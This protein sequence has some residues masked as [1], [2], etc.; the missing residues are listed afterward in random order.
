M[1]VAEKKGKAETKYADDANR[2]FNEALIGP[3]KLMKEQPKV[4]L[5]GVLNWIPAAAFSLLLVDFLSKYGSYGNTFTQIVQSGDSAPIS[6]FFSRAVKVF[7]DYL[8]DLILLGIVA[9]LITS[10]VALIYAQIVVQRRR[11][12]LRKTG[13]KEI[14]LN[15]AFDSGFRN[16]FGILL[17]YI[18]F[19]VIAI[20][21]IIIFGTLFVLFAMLGI[22]GVV[23]IIPLIFIL[24]FFALLYRLAGWVLSI[25]IV[26]DNKDGVEA[27]RDCFGFAWNNKLWGIL[28]L[29][30][31]SIISF[32]L[33]QIA[34]GIGGIQM[35]GVPL[36]LVVGLIVGSWD[37]MVPAEMYF[38]FTGRKPRV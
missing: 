10:L 20:G 14:M 4:L 18:L 8:P 29:I 32:V 27:V 33:G 6:A 23:L 25:S 16:L 17:A 34:S 35:I 21:G 30:V 15:E 7:F 31:V 36:A 28:M 11:N 38:E 19:F 5:A 12:V 26:I 37:A 22:F 9:V 1:A 2:D 13:V 24:L 3:F